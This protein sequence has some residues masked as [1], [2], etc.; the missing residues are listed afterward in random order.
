V[1][2]WETCLSEETSPKLS[3]KDLI[4]EGFDASAEKLDKVVQTCINRLWLWV[5]MVFLKN[6]ESVQRAAK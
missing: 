5:A 1:G 4:L 3:G 6:T 2:A